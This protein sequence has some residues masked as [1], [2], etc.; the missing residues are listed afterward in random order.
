MN[1]GDVILP[2]LIVLIVVVFA[3]VALRWVLPDR[4]ALNDPPAKDKPTR[5]GR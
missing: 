1:I 3:Y 2:S 4:D 5:R